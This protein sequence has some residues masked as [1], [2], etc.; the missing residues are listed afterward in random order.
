MNVGH[1]FDMPTMFGLSTFDLFESTFI[2]AIE[3]MCESQDQQAK[4][5]MTD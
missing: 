1:L 4:E 2:E 3:Q 5:V